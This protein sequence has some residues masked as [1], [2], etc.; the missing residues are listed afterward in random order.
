MVQK[1]KRTWQESVDRK[2]SVLSFVFF[3]LFEKKKKSSHFFSSLLYGTAAACSDSDSHCPTAEAWW[4][5]D[6]RV[7]CCL[8]EALCFITP[9]SVTEIHTRLCCPP[10][11]P[12]P[13]TIGG[14]SGSIFCRQFEVSVS[15]CWRSARSLMIDLLWG[16]GKE[17][18]SWEVG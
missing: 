10:T 16:V 14:R 9:P 17:G 7:L 6:R 5:A 3:N 8:V 1:E 13:T 2:V 18:A 12:H 11:L 4:T 15:R